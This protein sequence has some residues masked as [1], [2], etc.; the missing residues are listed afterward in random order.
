MYQLFTFIAGML[1]TISITLNAQ[2]ALYYDNWWA[3]VI[4]HGVGIV[5]AFLGMLK[6]LPTKQQLLAAPW[7]SYAGGVIGVTNVVFNNFSYTQISVTSIVALGLLGQT[8]M[9]LAVDYWGLFGAKRVPFAWQNSV[10]LP[11][12]L[13]GIM[14]LMDWS[15]LVAVLAVLCSLI[16]GFSTVIVRMLNARLSEKIGAISS[17]FVA[18]VAGGIT[19]FVI[20]LMVA[21]QTIVWNSSVPWLVY[22]GGAVGVFVLVLLNM[23]IPKIPLFNSTILAFIGQMMASLVIDI[24]LGTTIQWQSIVGG[25]VI[26]CGILFQTLLKNK[27]GK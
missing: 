12:A 24:G 26:A 27:K 13:L 7:W 14:I 4:V 19:A 22:I 25:L 6:R 5:I 2:L 16:S 17:S 21:R 9:A 11:F 1:I 20:T 8:L 3:T 23:S 15:N 10:G 18:H